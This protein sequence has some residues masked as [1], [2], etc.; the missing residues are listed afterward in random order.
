MERIKARYLVTS[1]MNNLWSRWSLTYDSQESWVTVLLPYDEADAKSAI[2][3]MKRMGDS[4]QRIEPIQKEFIAYVKSIV[5]GKPKPVQQ[6]VNASEVATL[7]LICTKRGGLG[8]FPGHAIHCGPR[9]S[10][11]QA[12]SLV[13]EYES[14]I[15]GGKW[16]VF[17]GGRQEAMARGKE[18]KDG[19]AMVVDEPLLDQPV[20]ESEDFDPNRLLNADKDRSL[21]F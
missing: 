21:P 14:G 5:S 4:G 13:E 3:Q 19:V 6:V 11:A 16:E 20:E 18:I 15:I 1:H 8:A 2:A 9:T 7:W 17:Q 12:E 10:Q